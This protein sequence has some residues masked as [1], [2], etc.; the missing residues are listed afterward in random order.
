M[1][2]MSY[3]L[4]HSSDQPDQLQRPMVASLPQQIRS[5]GVSFRIALDKSEEGGFDFSSLVG[6]DK[7][8]LLKNLPAKLVHCQPPDYY[9][10]VK[11]IGEVYIYVIFVNFT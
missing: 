11:Q 8:K 2:A 9:K 7:I 6:K 1:G 5:C 10:I 4:K 3:D